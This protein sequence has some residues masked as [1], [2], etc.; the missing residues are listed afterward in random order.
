MSTPFVLSF[1]VGAVQGG[2]GGPRADGLD[3]HGHF[4]QSAVLL[5][6]QQSHGALPCRPG[7]ALPVQLV[8]E[9]VSVTIATRAAG[10]ERV[11]RGTT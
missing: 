8:L 9:R 11:L 3:H 4:Q 6:C 2:R 10:A 1:R 7:A 5:Q